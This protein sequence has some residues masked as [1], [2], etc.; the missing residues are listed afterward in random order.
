[1][2]ISR[3]YF[4]FFKH[5][6]V[7]VVFIDGVFPADYFCHSFY[8]ILYLVIRQICNFALGEAFKK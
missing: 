8:I 3:G 5:F 4:E 6:I 7:S 2:F 1:L